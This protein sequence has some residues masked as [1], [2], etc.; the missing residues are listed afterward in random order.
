MYKS[1]YFIINRNIVTDIAMLS[2]QHYAVLEKLMIT[3]LSDVVSRNAR[4]MIH[5]SVFM[6]AR[7]VRIKRNGGE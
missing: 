3:I 4:Y 2:E 5:I 7:C 6:G 1:A